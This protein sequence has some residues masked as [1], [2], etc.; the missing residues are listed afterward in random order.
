MALTEHELI[1]AGELLIAFPDA[2]TARNAHTE[3]LCRSL[4]EKGACAELEPRDT[5]FGQW[6]ANP[7][8]VAHLRG[9]AESN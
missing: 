4:A 6:L 5:E 7:E 3:A 1:A 2:L 8:Y 9:T